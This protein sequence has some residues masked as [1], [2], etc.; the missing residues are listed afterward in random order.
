MS[1]RNKVIIGNWKMHFT[2]KQAVSFAGKLAAKTV[3]EGVIVGIAPTNLA[4][5]EVAT[6]SQK[7][8]LKIAAQNAHFQDEG[9]FTGEISMPMLRGIA[10]YIIIGHSERRHIFNEGIT[11]IR[12]K[13][14]A[15]VRSGIKPVLCIGE[16]LTERQNF[17]TKQ[18]INDQL[19]TAIADLTGDEIA[20]IIVAYEP[21][22]AI[23]N[24]SDYK[25]H[26]SALPEDAKVAADIIRRN[27]TEFYGQEIANK[28]RVLYGGSVTSDNAAAF[29]QTE[30]VDGLLVGGASLS[31]A[32]F[33]PIVEAAG[34]AAPKRINVKGDS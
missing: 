7:T 1:G 28:V 24:G 9:A 3:P 18:V 16:T 13:V 8:P 6:L 31:T 10:D 22:W 2:V 32:A 20:K 26:K 23:S 5:S 15:A 34:A 21:V 12:H 29:L 33:W 17:H 19:L 4:I 11:T 27:I 30:G 25:N 14:A